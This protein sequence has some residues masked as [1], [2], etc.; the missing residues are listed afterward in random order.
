[1]ELEVFGIHFHKIQ[2]IQLKSALSENK[3]HIVILKDLKSV[4]EIR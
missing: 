3:Y 2:I 4:K 1:M